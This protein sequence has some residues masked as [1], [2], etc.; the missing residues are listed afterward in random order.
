MKAPKA[1]APPDPRVVAEAQT[2][3]NKETATANAYLNRINQ[4]NPF[5][6]TTYT[7]DGTNPDGTPK[8]SESTAFS[9]PV[10]GLF[11]SYMGMTQGMADIGSGQLQGLQQQYS[12]PFNLDTEAENR[13]VALQRAR[14]D[15]Q[16]AQQDEALRNRLTN[17]GIREG[18][19]AWDRAL[20]R[21]GQISNDAYNSMYLGARQQGVNEALTQ[22]QLPLNEFN[23]MRTG[24]QVGMPQFS[25]VPGVQQ[26][27]TNVAGIYSDNYN[28]QMQA[29][30]AQNSQNNAF[31]GG[32]FGLGGS[33]L[34]APM[35]GGGSL[36]GSMFGASD[37][38][39]KKNI[40]RIGALPS[41]LPTY[42]WTYIWGG[43]RVRGVMAHEARELF[44]GAVAE[45][46]GFLAV[47]YGKVR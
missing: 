31:M 30:N 27:N 23:A 45:F 3:S 25:N 6:S 47:D 34:T 18:T 16:M 1:P 14:L 32:L 41:G 13:I 36:I 44:P 15:P 38:R 43:P 42:E 12:Q 17:Q 2:Q 24:S 5:G 35:T 4:T 39:L 20:T 22:R 40:V 37:I 19:E 28:Q 29:F 21:Q 9:Q 26:A 10:Q 46:G 7:V 8:F 33:I 11:D